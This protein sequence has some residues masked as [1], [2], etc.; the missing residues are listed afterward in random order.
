MLEQTHQAHVCFHVWFDCFSSSGPAK[1]E[2]TEDSDSEVTQKKK[3]GKGKKGKKVNSLYST[4]F[5]F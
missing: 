3:K 1:A 5:S 2:E 4:L